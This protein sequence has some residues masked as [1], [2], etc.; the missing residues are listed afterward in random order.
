MASHSYKK[1]TYDLDFPLWPTLNKKLTLVKTFESFQIEPSYLTCRFLV[2]WASHSYR[3]FY[4]WPDLYCFA[5]SVCWFV[6]LLDNSNIGHKVWNFSDRAFIFSKL[7]FLWQGLSTHTKI[8]NLWPWPSPV[9]HLKKKFLLVIGFEPFQI[10]P[11]C[12]TCRFFVTRASHSYRNV[13]PMT[14]TIT[15]DLF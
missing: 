13:L 8:F 6:C 7:G 11:S 4:L 5:R 14:L 3:N 9:T 15:C 10:E 1:M 2:T 12:L